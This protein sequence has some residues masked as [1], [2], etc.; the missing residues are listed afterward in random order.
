MRVVVNTSLPVVSRGVMVRFR[1]RASRRLALI[2][3]PDMGTDSPETGVGR[4]SPSPGAVAPTRTYLSCIR[5][6]SNSVSM[7]SA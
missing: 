1:M 7:N 4:A 5:V 2:S 6:G 3:T